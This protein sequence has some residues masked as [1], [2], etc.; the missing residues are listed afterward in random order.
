MNNVC[1]KNILIM[2]NNLPVGGIAKALLSLLAEIDYEHY[3]VDVGL[4]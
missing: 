1:K 4:F 2:M 3:N